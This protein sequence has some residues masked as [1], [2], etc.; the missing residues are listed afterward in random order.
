MNTNTESP[1]LDAQGD[2]SPEGTRV[3][4]L[5]RQSMNRAMTIVEYD[6]KPELR[7]LAELH[8]LTKLPRRC[9]QYLCAKTVDT[10]L[11]AFMLDL[12]DLKCQE[13]AN[14]IVLYWAVHVYSAESLDIL[15][16]RGWDLS[17]YDG[18]DRCLIK[19]CTF[20]TKE[21]Y[22]TMLEKLLSLGVFPKDGFE[23]EIA[24]LKTIIKKPRVTRRVDYQSIRS[25]EY[26]KL[27]NEVAEKA[28]ALVQTYNVPFPDVKVP[29]DARTS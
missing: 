2:L 27:R 13:D 15:L 20:S 22:L 9:R 8:D 19:A 23:A 21:S 25:T 29:E 11:F 17:A 10:D 3:Y 18:I 1:L 24:R 12:F 6:C 16:A 4:D 14:S 28:I 5:I 26:D 7:T